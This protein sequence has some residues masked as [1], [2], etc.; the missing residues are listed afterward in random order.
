[1]CIYLDH[2]ASTEIRPQVLDLY[3]EQLKTIFANPSSMHRLG[4]TARKSLDNSRA[5]IAK[6]LGCQPNE[7]IL[8]SGGSESTN[9]AIKGF[10]DANPRLPRRVITSQG[11]HAATR[12]T[13]LDLQR[14]GVEVVWLGLERNGTVDLESLAEALSEPASLISLIHV[15]NET[16]AVNDLNSIQKLRNRLQPACAIHIDAVQTLGKYPLDFR[17]AGVDLMS[18]SGHK[19]GAPKGIGWLQVRSKTRLAPI[20]NGGGQQN[21]LR[22]GTENPPLTAALALACEIAAANQKDIEQHVSGLR[23]NFIRALS[24]KG[25]QY[26]VLSPQDGVPHILSIAFPGLRG[27]TMLHALEDKAIYISTG[28]ACASHKKERNHVL[29][30][31]GVDNAISEC[32]VRISFSDLNTPEQIESAVFEISRIC[33][34]LIR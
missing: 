5:A 10:L 3:H 12:E 7:L 24:E 2:T 13:L 34:W 14:K 19:L 32:A 17:Q 31:M 11:E 25:V 22:S 23:Q 6:V 28:S 20:L 26:Q 27:E 18:G 9:L 15:S 33:Q 29:Q 21:G 1:M 8:T 16:G 30:A 4:Q